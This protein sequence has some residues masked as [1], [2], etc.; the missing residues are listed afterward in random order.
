MKQLVLVFL[1][2]TVSWADAALVITGRATPNNNTSS[3][4]WTF[5]PATTLPVGTLGIL[6]I[7]VDNAGTNGSTKNLANAT[8]NDSV[9]NTWTRQQNAI[10][11]PGAALAG[12]EVALYTAPIVTQIG[13]GDSITV[14]F[15]V[16]VAAKAGILTSVAGSGGTPTVVA[17]GVVSDLLT[18]GQT[19]TAVTMTT[20]TITTNDMVICWNGA[21]AGSGNTITGDSDT[22]NGTWSTFAAGSISAGTIRC[23]RQQKLVTGTGTQTWDI[24][25]A[26]TTDWICGWVQVREAAAAVDPTDGFF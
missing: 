5:S 13:T 9:S 24:T 7:A 2:V 23:D 1:L 25:F 8:F 17:S 11:D 10:Y 14:T 26:S 22:T 3:T 19:G 18:T 6:F 4:T 20:G 15:S 16:A 12:V 21:E